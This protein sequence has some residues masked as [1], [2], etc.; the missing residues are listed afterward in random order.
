MWKSDEMCENPNMLNDGAKTVDNNNVED[1][2]KCLK[3]P[4]QTFF[5]TSY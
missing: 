1:V 3:N 4:F 5:W 2:T